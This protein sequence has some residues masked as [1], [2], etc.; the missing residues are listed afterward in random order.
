[1]GET[2]G[3]IFWVLGIGPFFLPFGL[4]PESFHPYKSYIGSFCHYCISGVQYIYSRLSKL[5]LVGTNI[6]FQFRQFPG[7]NRLYPELWFLST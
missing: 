5:A 4:H 1:M 3:K 6:I 2:S 7:L